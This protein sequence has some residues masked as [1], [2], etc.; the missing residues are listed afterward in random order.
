MPRPRLN[1]AEKQ[2][3]TFFVYGLL[4]QSYSRSQI[5]QIVSEKH[6]V[7]DRQIDNY[8]KAARDKFTKDI[9][10]DFNVKKAEILAQYQDLYQQ[11]YEIEDYK[12][13]K[14][15]LDEISNIYGVKAATK[16]QL[17]GNPDKPI[18]MTPQ[19]III[20]ERER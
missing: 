16:I 13:C 11:S 4:L 12:A 15:I 10:I 5:I 3:I 1:N 2:K 6:K 9:E 17:E 8:I 7:S 20:K 18:S 14:S 19:T